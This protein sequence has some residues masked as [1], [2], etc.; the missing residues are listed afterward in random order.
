VER[1]VMARTAENGDPDEAPEIERWVSLRKLRYL[2]GS[3]DF[4]LSRKSCS[5]CRQEKGDFSCNAAQDC[6]INSIAQEAGSIFEIII[7]CPRRV[8]HRRDMA[9]QGRWRARDKVQLAGL[10]FASTSRM[11][12]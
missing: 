4:G 6:C 10:P 12:R 3:T 8:T 2:V 7:S 1:L 9:R 11:T 5:V